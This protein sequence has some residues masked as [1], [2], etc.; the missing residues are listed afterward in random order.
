MGRISR[1]RSAKVDYLEIWVFVAEQS[2]STARADALIAALDERLELLAR[3][4]N[5]GP[6]RE[7]LGPRVRT[8]PVGPY[9]LIYEPTPGGIRLHR[10]VHGSRDLHRLFR[11]GKP[12]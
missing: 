7:D 9:L 10:A 12:R 4:P 11:R 6:S 8:F 2:Q 1:S 3:H 5:A